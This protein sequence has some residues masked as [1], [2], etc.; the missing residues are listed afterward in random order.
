M[1]LNPIA[2]SVSG[3]RPPDPDTIAPGFFV[4]RKDEDA[5]PRWPFRF[6][7]RAFSVYV[8]DQEHD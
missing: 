5:L 6:Y 7:G 4:Y 8:H 3:Q 1:P 2:Y